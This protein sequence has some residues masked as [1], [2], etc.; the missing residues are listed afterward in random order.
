VLQFTNCTIVLLLNFIKNKP[1]IVAF[2][3]VRNLSYVNAYF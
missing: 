1:L 2:Y 3:T